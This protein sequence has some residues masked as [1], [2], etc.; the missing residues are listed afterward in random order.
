M[1]EHMWSNDYLNIPWKWGGDTKEG[2]DCLGVV[3]LAFKNQRKIDLKEN[4][5]NKIGDNYDMIHKA[6]ELGAQIDNIKDLKEFDMVFFTIRGEVAH[7]G[8][9]VNKFGY[10]LHQLEKKPSRVSNLNGDYWAKRFFCG[11]R[12]RELE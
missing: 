5:P 4:S 11:I 6:V 1:S 10:F 9:M 7:M 2:C 8:I 3:K 12:L